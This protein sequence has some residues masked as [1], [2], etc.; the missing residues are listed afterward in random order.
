MCCCDKSNINGELGYKWQP[1]DSAGVRWPD[2]P[3]ITESDTLLSDEPGRCGGID[4]HCH[5]YRVIEGWC[6][7]LLYKHGGGE[8]RIRLSNSAAM[9]PLL[10]ALDSNARYWLLN[11]IYHAY[12]DG[13]MNG[14][15]RMDEQWRKAAAEKRIKTRKLPHNR[16][17]KVW[18]EPE[19]VAAEGRA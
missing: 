12:N 9:R 3:T 15:G 16:G 14:S 11:S 13:Q 8:G 7:W 17:V 2:P 18:R 10:G 5:H 1:N 19:L 4:S 6:L